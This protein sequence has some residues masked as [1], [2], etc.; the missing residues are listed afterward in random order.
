MEVTTSEITKSEANKL[1]NKLITKYIDALE[2]EKINDIRKYILDILNNMNSIFTGTYFLHKDV[3]KVAMFEWSIAERLKLRRERTNGIK[4]KEQ[5]ISNEL[6]KE[7]FSD[8]SNV[9]KKLCERKNAEI[10]KTQVDLIKKVLSRLQRTIDY[11]PKGK[12]FKIEE[13]KKIFNHEKA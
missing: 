13:N 9:F 3:P 7:Y 8:A 12:M 4:R 5:T 6:F 1:Y 11:V 10:N 2:I